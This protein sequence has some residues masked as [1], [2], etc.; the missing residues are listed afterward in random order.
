[1]DA[2]IGDMHNLIGQQLVKVVPVLVGG[3][4]NIKPVVSDSHD[5]VQ[6][7]ITIIN[8]LLYTTSGKIGSYSM[9]AKMKCILSRDVVLGAK[10][11]NFSICVEATW[12][13]TLHVHVAGYFFGRLMTEEC[14][15]HWTLVA[16]MDPRF[17]A[18]IPAALRHH[19]NVVV[20]C[21]FPFKSM[22]QDF[23][24]SFTARIEIIDT[25]ATI[26]WDKLILF[27]VW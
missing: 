13:G 1:M 22:Q 7:E 6:E 20:G 11:P 26:P 21:F 25:V 17:R 3:A 23:A 15:L 27:L 16:S 4:V 5:F 10:V 9:P 14:D 2:W 24:A 12:F 18:R 8:L 19:R